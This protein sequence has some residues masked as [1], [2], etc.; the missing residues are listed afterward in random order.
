M[1]KLFR[2]ASVL[3]IALPGVALAQAT[4]QGTA[5]LTAAFQTYLSAT[6]GVVNV[7]ADGDAYAVTL[8]AGPFIAMIPA[9]AGVTLSMS[10][11]TLRVTDNGDGTWGVTQNQPFSMKMAAAGEMNL[12]LSIAGVDCVG[13]YDT[14]LKAFIQNDCTLQGLKMLQET[15]P[16]GA[17]GTSVSDLKLDTITLSQT[18]AAGANGGVD[19]KLTYTSSGLTQ[20][21]SEPMGAGMPPLDITFSL[22]ESRDTA[23]VTGMRNAALLASLAWVV[24]N[25]NEGAMMA[26]RT[27]LRDILAGAL[28]IWENI[29]A[30]GTGSGVEI[31]TPV[32]P[33]TAASFG[34]DISMTGAVPDGKIAYGL[35]L[36]ALALSPG[37]V[38]PFAEALIPQSVSMT[39]GVE[40]YDGA[41]AAQKLLGLFDLAPGSAPGPE[42]E[43]ELLQALLPDGS[44]DIVLSPGSVANATY[45]LTYEGRMQAGPNM[46][47]PTGT[48][49]IT[50]TG[51][52]AA[53]AALDGAPDEV[54]MEL[55][56]AMG[57]ARQ[58]ATEQADGSLVWDID[59]SV[60]G[61][62]KVNGM[63]LMG[64]Q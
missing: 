36:D 32:G 49:R 11:V 50:A 15:T 55:L 1:P 64:M 54:K 8:D 12:D 27:A 31:T 2:S 4:P 29:A 43:G 14:T 16:P 53:M 42:F 60:P 52:D 28:P 56:P 25:P 63:D 41:A 51:Y 57:I 3:A 23:T 59:A 9:Q 37:M 19:S 45:T 13:T 18:G 6:P 61:S 17:L 34:Y 22:A 46:M 48:A 35:R 21:I 10:P 44:V 5:E 40:S 7:V 30:S 39:F 58:F 24:A 38:P 33:V 62:L 20:R 26:N 47:M